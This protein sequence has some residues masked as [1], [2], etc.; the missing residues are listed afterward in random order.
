MGS[1]VVVWGA[2][3][4]RIDPNHEFP[5]IGPLRALSKSHKNVKDEGQTTLIFSALIAMQPCH[6]CL[7]LYTILATISNC[8]PKAFVAVSEVAFLTQLRKL[9]A[10]FLLTAEIS[11]SETHLEARN[12]A[13]IA[14][15]NNRR[16]ITMADPNSKPPKRKQRSSYGL[17]ASG[18][19][20]KRQTV[21]T[22]RP[23]WKGALSDLIVLLSINEQSLLHFHR[24][25]P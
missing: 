17:K 7:L 20:Q 3:Q 13:I 19:I 11:C 4:K 8:S 12:H 25:L 14:R 9:F 22:H 1:I 6:Q 10:F 24:Y 23:S 16:P 15:L 18:A 2:A 5:K 21:T